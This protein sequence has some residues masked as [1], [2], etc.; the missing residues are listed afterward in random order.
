MSFN[1]NTNSTRTPGPITGNP[2]NGLC[3]KACIHVSRVFDA[4]INQQPLEGYTLTLTNPNPSTY[5][6][7]LTF[8][9]GRSTTTTGTITAL[10]VTPLADQPNYS[11]VQITVDVPVAVAYTDA[12]GTAGTA[13]GVITRTLDIVMRFPQASIFPAAV[14]AKVNAVI[15]S[16]TYVSDLTFTVTCCVVVMLKVEGDVELV[17]PTYG[18]C[19]IPECQPYTQEVS[20]GVFDAPLFPRS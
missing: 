6:A 1:C 9:S 18:Y 3:E 19:Q 10:T 15:A 5:V 20:T 7:P 14:T 12:N 16:G 13:T 8:V 4:C 2:V 11:R 17:V